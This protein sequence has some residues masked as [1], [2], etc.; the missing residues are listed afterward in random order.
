M[1]YELDHLVKQYGSRVVLSVDALDIRAGEIFVIVGASGAGKST[2]LRLLALLENPTTGRVSFCGTMWRDVN[3]MPIAA[4]RRITLLFQRPVLLNGNVRANIAYPLKVRGISDRARVMQ[5]IDQLG[6]SHLANANAASLSGGESQRVALARA[7]VSE[8]EVLLLDEPTANLDPYNVSL[9]EGIIR[10]YHHEHSA[11]IVIVTH[12]VFQARRLAE[13]AGL[14]L[15]GRLIEV[16]ARAE[17]FE[18]P[19]DPRVAE[20]IRGEM[21]Y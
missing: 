17:F 5:L 9:I 2:L 12:S 6:L 8:P 15:D 4:R 19:R 1:F 3:K 21:I 16:G 18:S 10:A 14:L 20:F 11:T 7:L 13:R